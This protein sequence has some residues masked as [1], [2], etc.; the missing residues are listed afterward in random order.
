MKGKIFASVLTL[1]SLV[2]II[3]VYQLI[4]RQPQQRP[5]DITKKAR[6]LK[7]EADLFGLKTQLEHYQAEHGSY[8]TTREG[9]ALLVRPPAD[10]A[11][12]AHWRQYMDDI[13]SDSWRRPYQYLSPGRRDKERFDLFSL[14]PDGF[15]SSDDIYLSSE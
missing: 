3:T 10:P 1:L 6:E 15:E 9:L 2:T 5:G 7:V 13:P 4:L 8:P 12:R 14:G 11:R